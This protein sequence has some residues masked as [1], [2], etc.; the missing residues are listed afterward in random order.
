MKKRKDISREELFAR[1]W[2]RPTSEIAKE[3]GVSDVAL[4]NLCRRLQV[5]KPPRGYWARVQ[6]GKTPRRPP[7]PAFREE[8]EAEWRAARAK[9]KRSVAL[10]PLQQRFVD[11][12]LAELREAGGLDGVAPAQV[13]LIHDLGPDIAARLL[14]RIQA[15]HLRWIE[16]GRTGFQVG[17]GLTRSLS[18]LIEK[19]LPV[20]KSQ[21]LVLSGLNGA[22][23]SRPVVLIRL[24]A[25]LQERLADLARLVQSKGLAHVVTPL[26]PGDHA[27]SAHH[28]C[29]PDHW[30][31]AE[32]HLCV[33]AGEVWVHGRVAAA[34]DQESWH[35]FETERVALREV[36]P[37][38][39]LPVRET[40]LSSRVT[41]SSTRPFRN[42]L[43]ALE[44]A[45][46]LFGTILNA[47]RDRENL[48]ADDGLA[49]ADTLW[50][51]DIR[52]F[53]AARKAWIELE[54]E[55]ERWELALAAERS[56]LAMTILGVETGDI[57]VA[58]KKGK[59]LRILLD[60]ATVYTHENGVSFTLSGKRFRKDGV[61]GRLD[62][63]IYI[64]LES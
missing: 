62:E 50:Y 31:S 13:R 12:A 6:S 7:L 63:T 49:L 17:P 55:A 24:T 34:W 3:L 23:T 47:M 21:L 22:S 28:L 46:N 18:S 2:A 56:A 32:S 25:A 61:L 11:L 60:T 38:G 51:P 16:E 54:R 57:V 9:A 41:R 43:K 26:A 5:P 44:Q 45:E 14:L 42:R 1:V 8:L 37:L 33:S 64:H 58:S 59:A 52:P 27:W 53:S 4:A 40:V 30:R 19:L 36:V 35:V 29:S 15:R 10:S 39:L 20:A 48:A